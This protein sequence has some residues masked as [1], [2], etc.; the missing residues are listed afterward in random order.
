MFAGRAARVRDIGVVTGDVRQRAVHRADPAGL[1]GHRGGLRAWAASLVIDGTFQIGTLVA[2]AALLGRLYGPITSLSNVQVDVMTALVS[3]DRV[4]EVLDLKP[5]IEDRPDARTLRL[6]GQAGSAPGDPAAEI[7]FDHVSFRYPTAVGGLAGLAGVHRAAGA[8]A[9]R[10]RARTCCTTSSF[11]A[12]GRAAHRA[13]RAVRR[14]QDHDHP[15]G[16]PGCTTRHAGAVRI[17]GADLRDVTQDSLH[18]AVGVVTQDAHMF[19][20]TIRANLQLRPPGRHR[21]GAD[22]GLPGGAD[23]GPDLG[24]ARRPGHRRR[25]PRLPA[26]RRREA[27]GR[28][29]PAAAQGA[30]RWSCSTRPPRTWTPSPRRRCSGR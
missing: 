7:E 26:V 3:F 24:A 22:R 28:A 17:G 4:F 2:L 16:A 6:A 5:L 15:P 29:G 21:G 19:H 23:L 1:A 25:R 9:R 30:R 12:P 13:G 27:A 14:G 10:R 11:R 8:R 20:D 18:D